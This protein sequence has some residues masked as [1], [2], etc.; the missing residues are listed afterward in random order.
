MSENWYTLSSTEFEELVPLFTNKGSRLAMHKSDRVYFGNTIRFRRKF[1][2]SEGCVF[3]KDTKSIKYLS[4]VYLQTKNAKSGTYEFTYQQYFK[5]LPDLD[6]IT[7]GIYRQSSTEIKC[8][9][10]Y[11]VTYAS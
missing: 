7:S 11:K 2:G 10:T 3:M 6:K 1:I 8:S 4:S 9:K 5:Q